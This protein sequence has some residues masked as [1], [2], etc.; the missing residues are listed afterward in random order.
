MSL[1]KIISQVRQL[2]EDKALCVVVVIVTS[3]GLNCYLLQLLGR[4]TCNSSPKDSPAINSYNSFVFRQG[5]VSRYL[6]LGACTP[7]KEC[8]NRF[9]EV[10]RREGLGNKIVSSEVEH[11]VPNRVAGTECDHR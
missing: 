3:V 4:L 1:L 5:H 6:L 9:D 10:I 7:S 2:S 8:L 11:S